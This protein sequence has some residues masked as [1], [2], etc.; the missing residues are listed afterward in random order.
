MAHAHIGG[1]DQTAQRQPRNVLNIGIGEAPTHP[2]HRADTLEENIPALGRERERRV[3]DGFQLM[4]AERNHAPMMP[5]LRPASK[6]QRA[7]AVA[8]I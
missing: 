5:Q 6:G 1:L 8:M 3:H 4:I 2:Q 7:M